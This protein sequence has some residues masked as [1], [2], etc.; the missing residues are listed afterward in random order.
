MTTSTEVAD[1]V[2]GLDDV[3]ERNCSRPLGLYGVAGGGDR[4]NF[5]VDDGLTM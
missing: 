3:V 2:T 4:S 5:W 1:W